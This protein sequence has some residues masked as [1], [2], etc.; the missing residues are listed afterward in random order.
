MMASRQPQILY[1]DARALQDDNYR[2][3]GVGQHSAAIL[4]AIRRFPWPEGRPRI[5][6]VVDPFL[7]PL[8]PVHDLLFDEATNL[9]RARKADGPGWFISLSPMTHDPMKVSGFLLDPDLYRICLFYDLIPLDFPER[10]LMNPGARSD[11]LVALAWLRRFDAFASISEFSAQAVIAR[12]GVDPARV[13][14]SNVAVRS[15]LLPRQG[16]SDIP[17]DR[18]RHIVVAGGGDPRKNPECALAAHAASAVLRRQGVS[19]S[20]F[21][22]YPEPMR[23]ELRTRYRQA[24]GRPQDLT[25]HAHLSDEALRALYQSSL[26]TIV[27]SRAEGFSIPI[28]ESSAASTPV[29]ASDVGAHPELARDPA[30]RFGPDDV[31]AL[32]GQLER[33][34]EDPAAWDGLRRAQADLWQGYTVEAVG[35]RFMEGVLARVPEPVTTATRPGSPAIQRGARPRIAVLS[36]LPPAQSGVADYTAMTLAPLKAVAEL[37]VFTPTAD[38]RWEEGWASLQPVAAAEFSAIRFDATISVVGNSDHHVEIVDYLLE[39]G[40]GCI[41]HDARMIN[42]YYLLRGVP[43]A[44]QLASD[45]MGRPVDQ[46]ELTRWLHNQR[47]L[48]T[49]FLSEVARASE[50]LMVHSPTTANEIARLYGKTPRLLPFA[51][52]RRSLLNRLKR[53]DRDRA[54]KALGIPADRVVLVTFGLVS[55]DKAPLE[56][57]WALNMLRSWG[58]DAEL[59]FCGRNQHM[60]AQL[61]ALANQLGLVPFVRTFDT[62]IDDATYDN[63]LVAAD[64]GVQLRTYQMGGLS[65]A[66]NDCISAALPSI[67]NAHLAEAMQAPDFVKRVPDGLSS[68]LIAEAA[69]GILSES[70]RGQ[71]PV[72]EARAFAETRSP[73]GY[74]QA[75]LGHLD[76]DID[77]KAAMVAA[78]QG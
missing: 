75:L 74:C 42:F 68:L 52:Y 19:I 34:V 70:E 13:F 62:A 30:W 20:V 36:P 32:R 43:Q 33:L 38:A 2:F 57:I 3:R 44:M 65:G 46:G 31:D 10:Y 69:L 15:E 63:Y 4:Q 9:K 60:K 5:V 12:T 58:V 56:L 28:V 8:A 14:V 41:A 78:G 16:D 39:N 1:V 35:Q 54:R 72:A 48:P 55:E 7:A 73:A 29:L 17:H 49:L 37:H 66:L 47:E 50:P 23:D 40:G 59:V 76:I 18:R 77:V 6:A 24:G 26:V 21:G 27:P 25:F 71:R 53:A 51:Q 64:I 61:G 67:A 11:Y 22:A 45:E